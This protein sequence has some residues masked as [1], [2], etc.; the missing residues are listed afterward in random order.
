[1][2]KLKFKANPG[3]SAEAAIGS[4]VL[5]WEQNLI[6]NPP[7]GTT[8]SWSEEVSKAAVEFKEKML[9]LG[10]EIE[11]NLMDGQYRGW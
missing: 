10:G 2:S 7:E 11:M 9:A 3:W 5:Q 6:A 4:L 8:D 1:M